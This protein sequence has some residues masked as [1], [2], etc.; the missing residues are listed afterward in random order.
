LPTS[1][2]S[3]APTC[4]TAQ[5]HPPRLSHM[6]K[7]ASA[8][9]RRLR[10][11]AA[12]PSPESCSWSWSCSWQCHARLQAAPQGSERPRQD[13]RAAKQAAAG[14]SECE[15]GAGRGAG[16]R[17]GEGGKG[18]G[19]QVLRP[20]VACSLGSLMPSSASTSI[21]SLQ[22]GRRRWRL[23]APGHSRQAS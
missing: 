2:C 4:I 17:R 5:G 23:Q 9:G 20:T 1:S 6:N 18:G 22:E 19:G 7:A 13:A 3:C 21:M 10:A 14:G 12:W 15:C 8:R 16:R 11:Q